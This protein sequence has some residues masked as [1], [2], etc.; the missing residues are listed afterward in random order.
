MDADEIAK[1]LGV[2][3][4]THESLVD[5]KRAIQ[6]AGTL[7]VSPAMWNLMESADDHELQH[8][9]SH[10]RVIDMDSGELPPRDFPLQ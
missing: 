6:K 3:V 4:V 1:R 2:R 10:L 9:M 7:F 5:S 8:L